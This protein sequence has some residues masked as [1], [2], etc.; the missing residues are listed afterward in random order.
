MRGAMGSSS[1]AGGPV[2]RRAF[3]FIEILAT[4]A[5]LGIVLPAVMAGISLCLS[6]ANVAK[7]QSQA[8]SLAYGKLTELVTEGQLQHASLEGDFGEDWPD[9]RWTAQVSDWDEAWLRQV[10]V[11]V[12]WSHRGID[13]SVTLSTLVYT[14]GEE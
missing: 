14:G 11:T 1:S 6:T 4:M 5:L 2:G 8:S 3:T 9:F 7:R 10:D 12:W 13:R